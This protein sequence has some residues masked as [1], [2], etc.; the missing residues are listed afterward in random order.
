[1]AIA[2]GIIAF[3]IGAAGVTFAVK[4][5][6]K[7][8]LCKEYCATAESLNAERCT[9]PSV[10]ACDSLMGEKVDLAVAARDMAVHESEMS[11]AVERL[12][13]AA[14]M[15]ESQGSQWRSADCFRPQEGEK[16]YRCRTIAADLDE[17]FDRFA[18]RL[19]DAS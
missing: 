17:Q 6:S 7:S 5:I 12:H 15:V 9:T 16:L 11:P 10:H 18:E 13:H 1:M 19:L 14:G 4:E 3:G 2:A 8:P